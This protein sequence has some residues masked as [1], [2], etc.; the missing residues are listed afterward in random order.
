[1]LLPALFRLLARSLW[2]WLGF[3]MFFPLSVSTTFL[4]PS[5]TFFQA[6]LCLACGS[7]M[8]NTGMFLSVPP[9]QCHCSKRELLISLINT[10]SSQRQLCCCLSS[11]LESSV[12]CSGPAERLQLFH[13]GETLWSKD[14]HNTV[15]LGDINKEGIYDL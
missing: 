1:M 6:S 14:R 3:G 9:V 13:A 12:W 8:S 10:H 5:C 11:F 7:F 4:R 15:L 2:A